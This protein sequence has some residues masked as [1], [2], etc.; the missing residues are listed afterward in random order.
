MTY[1]AERRRRPVHFGDGPDGLVRLGGLWVGDGKNFRGSCWT[2]GKKSA[3]F[4][5]KNGDNCIRTPS[6]R[7]EQEVIVV[8][9]RFDPFRIDPFRDL[10]RWTHQAFNHRTPSAMSMDAWRHDGRYELRIDLPGVDPASIDVTVEKHV[11]TVRGER[12]WAPADGAELLISERPQ[13]TFTRQ[14]FLG[15]NLDTDHIEARYEHGV[16]WLTI[17]EAETAKPRK[18]QVTVGEPTKVIET[19]ASAA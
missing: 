15:E 6:R 1:G 4:V 12:S 11:L 5:V 3:Y 9:M 2:A 17:P 18:V 8:L 10:E 13:G 16:L 14:V 19:S 7:R